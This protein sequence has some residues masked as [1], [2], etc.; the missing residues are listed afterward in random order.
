MRSVRRKNTAPEMIVRQLLYAAGYRYRLHVRNL[1]GSPDV[2]FRR[3][4]KAIFVHGCFWHSHGCRHSLRPRS[5]E[6][7]WQAKFERNKRRDEQNLSNLVDLG[8]DAMTIWE[9]ETKDRSGLL[10]RMRTFLDAGAT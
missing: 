1:P 2:V 9:C 3:R 5:R 6:D 4:K 7:Y 10:A 8:W